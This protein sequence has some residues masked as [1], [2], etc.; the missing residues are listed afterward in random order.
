[1]LF[2]RE[3]QSGYEIAAAH[4]CTQF[5]D[6]LWAQVSQPKRYLKLY[7]A[8][9]TSATPGG[10]LEILIFAGFD[11]AIVVYASPSV[12]RVEWI[13]TNRHIL[14][15][16]SPVEGWAILQGARWPQGVRVNVGPPL[17]TLVALN[18]SNKLIASK[19]INNEN[20]VPPPLGSGAFS[21]AGIPHPLAQPCR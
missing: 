3:S 10:T 13:G 1:M 12:S 18:A 8:F 11:G 21:N 2:S 5:N 19:T 14:D 7:Q 16:M 17:G 4:S 9:R 15:A 20:A 6:G